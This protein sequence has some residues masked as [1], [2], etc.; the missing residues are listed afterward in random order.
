MQNHVTPNTCFL[1]YILHP[2]RETVVQCHRPK[3]QVAVTVPRQQRRLH[4]MFERGHRKKRF[5]LTMSV[6]RVHKFWGAKKNPI[7]KSHRLSLSED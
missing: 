4:V 2:E 7:E 5:V 6:V 3:S 1:S